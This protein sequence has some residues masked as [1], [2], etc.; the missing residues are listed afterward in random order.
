MG[1][2]DDMDSN[3]EQRLEQLRAQIKIGI[4]ALERGEF[5]EVDDADLDAYF[6]MLGQRK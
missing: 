3:D 5:T 6:E 2:A 4:E 1:G